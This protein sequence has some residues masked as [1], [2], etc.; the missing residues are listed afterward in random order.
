MTTNEGPTVIRETTVVRDSGSDLLTGVLIGQAMGHGEHHHHHDGGDRDY[1]RSERETP[2]RYEEPPVATSSRG[3]SGGE[4]DFGLSGRGNNRDETDFSLSSRGNSGGEISFAAP[5][6][7][8][9]PEPSSG[10]S[11]FGSPDDNN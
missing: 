11:D 1:G 2:R 9:D 3:E 5:D 10:A 4:T 6:P 8:P 7:D